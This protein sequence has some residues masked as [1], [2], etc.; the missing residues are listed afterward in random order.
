MQFQVPQFIETEDKIVGPLTLKQFLYFAA[1]GGLSFLLYFS[2]QLWLFAIFAILFFCAAAALA[3]IKIN[4][5]PLTRI[6]SA[7]A[8][9]YWQPQAYVWQPEHPEVK[10][11][12]ASLKP[13][14]PSDSSLESIIS[15]LALKNA[16]QNLQTGKKISDQQFL[17]KMQERYQVFRG[18][19][20]ERRAAR[21]VDY[22]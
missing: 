16:W 4:G 17:G 20:G 18:L 8:R 1:A 19:T 9:F 2:V 14:A 12:E 3:F 13:F 5:R 7:A 11:T 6:I 15:G 10:K 21:R 22:R